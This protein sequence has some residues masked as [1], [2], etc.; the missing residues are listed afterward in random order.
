MVE[1]VTQ[2]V[3]CRTRAKKKTCIKV[4]L[5][6]TSG[7]CIETLRCDGVDL[8]D[9]DDGGGVFFRQPEHVP[10]HTR[11]FPQILLNKLGA[12]HADERRCRQRE[13]R[14][15]TTYYKNHIKAL[16]CITGVHHVLL[17]LPVV[18][19]ATALANMVLPQ[20]GGP[21]IRTPLGGSMPIWGKSQKAEY[22]KT[23]HVTSFVYICCTVIVDKHLHAFLPPSGRSCVLQST[24]IPQWVFFKLSWS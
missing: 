14:W 22:K 8:V 9:E 13:N 23:S 2:T 15:N 3:A 20:P 24:Y 16:Q 18:W 7:L 5:F 1:F 4:G 12:D 11:T 6:R 17:H 21:Y 19:W 10:H